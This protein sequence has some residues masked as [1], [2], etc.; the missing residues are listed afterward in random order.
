MAE[1]YETLGTHVYVWIGTTC[2]R[3]EDYYNYFTID[4]T[5]EIDDPNYKPCGFCKDVG[6]R[7]Y[8]EDFIFCTPPLKKEVEIAELLNDSIILN[9]EDVV[10]KCKEIGIIKANTIFAYATPDDYSEEGC[11]HISKPYKES[12]NDLK[13]IGKFLHN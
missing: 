13:Y 12:Y 4:C 3:E 11:L 7:W 6:E 10:K 1:N 2:K 8:D 9:K 5:Y